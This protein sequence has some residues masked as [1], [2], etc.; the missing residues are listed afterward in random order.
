MIPANNTAFDAAHWRRVNDALDQALELDGADRVAFLS[1]LA[2]E[3]EPLGD[4][5]RR[6]LTRLPDNLTLPPD[7]ATAERRDAGGLTTELATVFKPGTPLAERGFD[8]LL[9]RALR[10]ERTALK[11]ARYQG[12]LCGAWRLKSV[13]GTGGMGEV[14]LAERAD[15]LYSAQAAVKFLRPDSNMDAFEARFAQERLLLARLN[16]PGIAR[17]LDAGRQFGHPFLVLEYVEGMPLL[18]YL[19][20]HAPTLDARLTVFRSI[21]EAVSY[22]HTQLVVHRDLKPSNVLVT[23]SGQVKLLD[24]G[25]AGLL[26]GENRDETT[27]SAA[28]RL[29]GRGL[30][31]EYAAPEQI[32]GEATG[33]ASDVYSLGALGYHLLSGHRA[34]L[35][36]KAGRAALEH[37][38][39][40]TDPARLSEAARTP[41]KVAAVDNFAAPSD[42][43]RIGGDLDAIFACAMRRDPTA[44]YRTVDEFLA[45]LRRYAER[46]PIA[47]RRTDRAYRARLWLRR[48]WLASTLGATLVLALTS[49]LGVS[50]WQAERARIEASRA[51]KT[52]DYLVELLANADPD[53]HGGDWP[54]A[55]RLLEQ[56]K[57]DVGIRFRDDPATEAR[58]SSLLASTFRSLSRDTEALPVAQRAVEISERINGANAIETALARAV[59][60][61]TLYWLEREREALAN[62]ELALPTL[63]TRLAAG[64]GRLRAAQLGYAN[65]LARLLEHD[66]SERAFQAYF[67][68]LG[69]A[70][71]DR[72]AR[73]VADG[74]YAR[75]LT[76]QGRWGDAFAI[77]SKN[78]AL[79]NAPPP[80][81]EKVALH[82][83]QSIASAQS[84]LGRYEGAEARLLAVRAA[85]QRLAGSRSAQVFDALNDLGYLYYRLGEGAKAE[86]AYTE[87]RALQEQLPDFEPLRKLSTEID[88]I[89]IQLFFGRRSLADNAASAKAVS[90]QIAALDRSQSDRGVWL[91]TRLA[92]I[93]DACG[94]AEAARELL[95][96][97]RAIALAIALPDG[98]WRRRIERTE[99]SMDRRL[100]GR[101][102]TEA[103]KSSLDRL[104]RAQSGGFSQRVVGS[105][106]E[107]ALAVA[108]TEPATAKVAVETARRSLP[109][110]LPDTHYARAL[111]EYVAMLIDPASSVVARRQARNALARALGH[112]DATRLLDPLPGFYFM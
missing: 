47:A 60:A 54:T 37:A 1:A 81:Q 64:D 105:Y 49:G 101:D 89:E 76:S 86:L 95:A 40:H 75:A 26:G 44:R 2:D 80:G 110:G 112:P 28:T 90:S 12:E 106:L 78:E 74:D 65:T 20:G 19:V 29:A 111:V 71:S 6:L 51:N 21:V 22:A 104:A 66:E 32:T 10:A 68:A 61:E 100:G 38:V 36:E 94:D 13:I 62:Y 31:I 87:L 50:I 55:L 56:A 91:Q 39:L 15:G 27:E 8:G 5:V 4:E 9:Q 33:V 52:A 14:W 72:W 57:A 11:S 17:L 96:S 84:V 83:R 7:R 63:V 69:D 77:L 108:G 18:E 70:P 85:W 59:L 109:P 24:F 107:Y 103:L 53:L 99:A 48:N 97:A 98:P 73:A 46:R 58:L 34:H 16:H 93:L 3:S 92:V 35:P 88:L 23:K 43:L 25:V 30:T 41:S 42:A 67:T 45:D 102:V 82:N 79:Y